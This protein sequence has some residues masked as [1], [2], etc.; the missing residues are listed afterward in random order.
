MAHDEPKQKKTKTLSVPYQRFTAAAA[1]AL[2]SK[3]LEIRT[4]ALG[5]W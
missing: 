1:I 4:C 2:R 5:D 3:I